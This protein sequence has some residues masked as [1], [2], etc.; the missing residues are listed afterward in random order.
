MPGIIKEFDKE[1]P[2][3]MMVVKLKRVDAHQDIYQH[4]TISYTI[5][6]T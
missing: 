4:Y 1:V 2:E 5:R 3:A 6:I